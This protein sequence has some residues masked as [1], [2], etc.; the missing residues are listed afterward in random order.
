[1]LRAILV[2]CL[3]S[4]LATPAFAATPTV[5]LYLVVSNATPQVVALYETLDAC[6]KAAQASVVVL[7][8]GQSAPGVTTTLICVP[9]D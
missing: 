2:A 7:P 3:V 1:M 9:A 4:V 6:L 8:K 5:T